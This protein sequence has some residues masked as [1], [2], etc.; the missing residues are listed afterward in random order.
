M[1]IS[2]CVCVCVCMCALLLDLLMWAHIDQLHNMSE[3]RRVQHLQGSTPWRAAA[4]PPKGPVLAG[5]CAEDLRIWDLRWKPG[6]LQEQPPCKA[7]GTAEGMPA[8]E[9]LLQGDHRRVG[10][11]QAIA[12]IAMHAQQTFH[13]WNHGRAISR[14]ASL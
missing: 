11:L 7:P 5:G 9:Q 10:L 13:G 2:M 8:A 3:A 14:K 12:T 4:A 6:A 1:H